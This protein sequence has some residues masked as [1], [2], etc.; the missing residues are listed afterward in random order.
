MQTISAAYFLNVL[1]L[2]GRVPQ[3]HGLVA[4]GY[5]HVFIRYN[6]SWPEEPFCEIASFPLLILH[7]LGSGVTIIGWNVSANVS[8]WELS[9]YFLLI[10]FSISNLIDNK[11]CHFL[12]A[13]SKLPTY[14][15]IAFS[16]WLPNRKAQGN[17]PWTS[18]HRKSDSFWNLSAG[19]SLA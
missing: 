12:L 5:I 17:I 16:P 10:P 14:S 15:D 19:H 8:L 1:S 9:R 18:T 2:S 4:K 11:T 6:A 7:V 13:I 3:W